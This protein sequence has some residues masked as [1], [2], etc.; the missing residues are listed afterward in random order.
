MLIQCKAV[1]LPAPIVKTCECGCQQT[2]EVSRRWRYRKYAQRF[3]SGHNLSLE[4][5]RDKSNLARRKP[6]YREKAKKA[7]QLRF[8]NGG[9]MPSRKGLPSPRKGMHLTNEQKEVLRKANLGKH[10]TEETKEKCRATSL[11]NGAGLWMLG[12]KQTKETRKKIS[13]SHVG[14]MPKNMQVP[15]KYG[16]IQRGWFEIGDEKLFFRSKWEANYALYLNFLIKQNLI[17]E[18]TYEKDVFVFEA[19]QF[20]TRS[21]RPDFKIINNDNSIEYHEVKGYMDAKSVTK[22]KRMAKYY[23][24]IKI[25]I[26]DTKYYRDIKKKV[27]GILHF[28]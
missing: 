7:A 8:L 20:G 25:V 13:D 22:L 24:A 19:I 26:I 1:G 2:F 17:R 27:G 15:G 21:Y 18:W 3:I 5:M 28:Y 12:K 10:H 11:A 4:G 16:N 14:I 23:P 9:F 6:E